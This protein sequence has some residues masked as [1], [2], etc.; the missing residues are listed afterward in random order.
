MAGTTRGPRSGLRD[1]WI[2]AILWVVF[3]IVG[4]VI[5]WGGIRA[6]MPERY[7]ET[8]AIVDDAFLW[9]TAMAVPVF[10][11]VFA[12]LLVSVVRHRRTPGEEVDGEPVAETRTLYGAW[13]AITGGLAVTLFIFPGLVGMSQL[14]RAQMPQ[15]MEGM[16]HAITPLVVD[17]DAA[18]WS[19]KVTYP[20]HDIAST[21]ELVLPADRHVEFNVRSL[22][23]LHSFWIPAFRVKIDAVPGLTTHF[24]VTPEATGTS[25]TDPLL[26]VQCAELCGL[27]HSTMAMPI[28]ILEPAAFDAWLAEQTGPECEP[29]GTELQI[30]ALN[31]AFNTSCLAAPADTPFTITFEN[32][33]PDIPHNV[34]IATSAAWTDVLFT[35]EVFNG[36]DTVTYEVPAIPAGTY[37]FR[38]DVHPNMA[39][40][41]I[42]K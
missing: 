7:A 12:F 31:I 19:W 18:K 1:E 37:A 29:G 10:A 6:V 16:D 9:L 14:H 23:I 8:A 20:Q 34:A 2:A 11:W 39:G 35:G 40:T 21:E 42:A 38:C 15:E 13:F 22:D 27:H 24:N 25:E 3:T 26:R 4:E 32:K 41:F 5:V 28:R 33:D 17:M 36:V 30:S